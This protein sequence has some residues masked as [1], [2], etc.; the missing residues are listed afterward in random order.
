MP[1]NIGKLIGKSSFRENLEK[2]IGGGNIR[3]I[4]ECVGN[5]SEVYAKVGRWNN[6]NPN[7][8]DAANKKRAKAVGINF[9]NKPGDCPQ[10]Y[11]QVP[12]SARYIGTTEYQKR[13]V[14]LYFLNRAGNIIDHVQIE[15]LKHRYKHK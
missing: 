4:C 6:H 11:A 1:E 5:D 10:R 14:E 2:N 3:Y 8:V 12:K 13:D 9:F 15:G 7:L